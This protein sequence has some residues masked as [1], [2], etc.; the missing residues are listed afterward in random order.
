[1][2]TQPFSLDELIPD[3]LEVTLSGKTYECKTARDLGP[4]EYAKMKRLQ[5]RVTAAGAALERDSDAETEDQAAVT[6]EEAV[7]QMFQMLI[8]E[9]APDVAGRIT[10]QK[11]SAMLE[12][13]RKQQ[14]KGEASGESQA[15]NQ[16][17]PKRLR[18][19]SSRAT[20]H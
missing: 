20:T 1:M 4:L 9:L 18:A 7:D 11:K 17:Q 16:T 14:P 10:F 2:N 6:I 8:P 15:P 5:R 19:S 13:W 3:A 12:W